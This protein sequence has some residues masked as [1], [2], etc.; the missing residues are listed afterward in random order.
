M[1]TTLRGVHLTP[2]EV[3][4]LCL[5]A[6][7]YSSKEVADRLGVLKR[8]VDF[9]LANIYKKLQVNNRVQA[10][11]SAAQLGLIPF[12]LFFGQT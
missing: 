2:T 9:H 4:V 6:R 8:A 7:G 5:I 3:K 12:K 10:I 11:N 1:G